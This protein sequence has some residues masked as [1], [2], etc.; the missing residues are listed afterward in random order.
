MKIE[1]KK[2]FR[3]IACIAFIIILV[4]LAILVVKRGILDNPKVLT[5]EEKLI[6]EE[7]D[8]TNEEAIKI[9][10]QIKEVFNTKIKNVKMYDDYLR[11][12]NENNSMYQVYFDTNSDELDV[13]I[14]T[15]IGSEE[16]TE[17]ER[18]KYSEDG[19]TFEE[20]NGEIINNT[21][22]KKDSDIE[23]NHLDSDKSSEDNI[24]ANENNSEV[25]EVESNKIED[26]TDINE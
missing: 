14:V 12:N 18:V 23:N 9:V 7:L 4:A 17:K 26:D 5:S 24:E 11:F 19:P 25:V 8:C 15:Y 13:D 6:K 3:E 10:R 16:L 2:F 21:K 22:D 1:H 20:V